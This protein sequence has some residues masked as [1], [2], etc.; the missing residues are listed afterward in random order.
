DQALEPAEL[1]LCDL[2]TEQQLHVDWRHELRSPHRFVYG[3]L[4]AAELA[5][6]GP[7]DL[8]L[9]LGVLYHDVNHVPMLAALNRATALGGRMLLETTVDPRPD[10]SVWLRWHPRTGKAKAVPTVAAVRLLL[11]WTGWRRV[12]R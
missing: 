5:T 4:R 9:F 3:D 11:S 7:F 10:A 6:L 12:R 2:A 8:V 1:V